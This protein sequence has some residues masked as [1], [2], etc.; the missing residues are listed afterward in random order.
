MMLSLR[1]LDALTHGPKH[2][3]EDAHGI[4]GDTAWV[5]D[6]ATGVG[7]G[8]DLLQPTGAAWLAG[9]LS[10]L[11]AAYAPHAP[12]IGTL[13]DHA[14]KGVTEAFEQ[15]IAGALLDLPDHPSACLGLVRLLDG[16][17][18]MACIGD[19]SV[20]HAGVN[21]DVHL[22]TD[23]A[24]EAFGARTLEA[25]KA[26]RERYPDEDPWPHIREQVRANRLMANQPG[27]Y[28]VVHPT[29][30]WIDRVHRAERTV[31]AGDKLLLASDGFWRLVD[32]FE[33]YSPVS[34]VA[35]AAEHGLA[36]LVDALRNAEKSDPTGSRAPR[37]KQHD[38]ATA[39]LLSVEEQ[40]AE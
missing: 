38:D 13:L 6:G 19:I 1:L 35:A 16:Q 5:I 34:L 3:N 29:L 4:L 31:Q 32:H 20:L 36:P 2:P 18:D 33:L 11:I 9:T 15:T 30:P 14:S 8:P 27:G 28:G 21:D 25:L 26:V 17:L 7:R 10:D 12:D 39:V 22:F 37:V 40:A 23:H 24:V